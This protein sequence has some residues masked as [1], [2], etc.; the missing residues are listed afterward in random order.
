MARSVSIGTFGH[1]DRRPRLEVGAAVARAAFGDQDGEPPDLSLAERLAERGHAAALEAGADAPRDVVDRVAVQEIASDERHADGRFPRSSRRDSSC[2]SPRRPARRDRAATGR[3]RPSR[4]RPPLR[5]AA[6]DRRRRRRALCGLGTQ[7]PRSSGDADSSGSSARPERSRI[8]APRRTDGARWGT[9]RRRTTTRVSRDVRIGRSRRVLSFDLTRIRSHWFRYAS[10]A[11]SK[12]VGSSRGAKWVAPGM[13]A[14]CP[15][16]IAAALPSV[17]LRATLSNSPATT[18]TGPA[19]RARSASRTG[20]AHLARREGD[21]EL[22]AIYGWE[23]REAPAFDLVWRVSRSE[24]DL[25]F[26]AGTTRV[27]IL[28]EKE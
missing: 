19:I 1:D 12:E 26:R 18:S 20:R 16:G 11:A 25:C 22:R 6:A 3:S 24:H 21:R 28:Q 27:R 9:R 23:V 17:W 5:P 4:R 14:I 8:A 13:I 2:S 10:I 15:F 7:L